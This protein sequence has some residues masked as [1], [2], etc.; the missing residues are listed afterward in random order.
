MPWRPGPGHGFTSAPRPWLPDP[1][2][3]DADTVA[4]QRSDPDSF[5]HRFRDL[6]HQRQSLRPPFDAP[7][8]WLSPGN[9]VI[10]YR[11]PGILVTLN[12]AAA[13]ATVEVPP[14]AAVTFT[15]VGTPGAVRIARDAGGHALLTLAPQQAAIIRTNE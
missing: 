11:R 10:G 1:G 15:S 13:D 6:L 14:S 3:D 8:H 12:G 9:P 5:L 2:R 7:V 4:A